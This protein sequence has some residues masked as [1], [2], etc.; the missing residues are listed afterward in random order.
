V[1]PIPRGWSNACGRGW[2]CWMP[3]LA[4]LMPTISQV[5][6]AFCADGWA[7]GW[8]IAAAPGL[9]EFAGFQWTFATA[10]EP[11]C[12]AAGFADSGPP[13]LSVRTRSDNRPSPD[14]SPLGVCLQR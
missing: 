13:G 14:P 12:R 8:S 7:F 4:R 11:L 2:R 6:V 3:A 10:S 9:V 1:L 5:P